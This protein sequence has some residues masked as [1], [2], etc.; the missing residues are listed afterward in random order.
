LKGGG[1]ASALQLKPVVTGSSG[2]F[3]FRNLPPGQYRV[4][5]D[6]SGYFH[7]SLEAGGSLGYDPRCTTC[8]R[9]PPE[10][11]VSRVYP[12][13][14]HRNERSVPI[15]L[16]ENQISAVTLPLLPGGV[17]TGRVHDERGRPLAGASIGAFRV[18]WYELGEPVLLRAVGVQATVD[19]R[20]EYRLFGLQPGKYYLRADNGPIV[21]SDLRKFS[22]YPG[23]A[24]GSAQAV[25]VSPGS[26][27]RNVNFGLQEEQAAIVSGS[28]TIAP[29]NSNVR[30]TPAPHR[31]H[32]L[33]IPAGRG[34]LDPDRVW[35]N[36]AVSAGVDPFAGK[37]E[38][39]G[40]RPGD[41]ELYVL[42][43]NDDDA[44]PD[45]DYFPAH[46]RITVGSTG[47][48]NVSVAIGAGS[49]IT[50]RIV[51]AEGAKLEPDL[52][53][54]VYLRPMAPVYPDINALT[55]WGD[56]WADVKP[57]GTFEISGLLD[58][59]Y[60]VTLDGLPSG[61]AVA[62]IR[63]GGRS[64]LEDGIVVESASVSM[65]I[66]VSGNAGTVR[67][68]VRDA[69]G[70]PVKDATVTLV[71]A[72]ESRRKFAVRTSFQAT[73]SRYAPFEGVPPGEYMLFAWDEIADGAEMNADLLHAYEDHGVRISVKPGQ[74]ITVD[75]PLISTEAVP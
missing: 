10:L 61:S 39:R 18:A 49:S 27:L 36:N 45:L 13:S 30:E 14:A 20:G 55:R 52:K 12:N 63:Q 35:F 66:V 24:E 51:M 70:Q 56:R 69:K 67:V 25:T 28:F 16:A 48:Q 64:V 46:Q 50:G 75:A 59:R 62:D 15:N 44:L 41:Y 43:R 31:L 7:P 26:E 22:Y 54:G 47:I 5:W 2:R 29:P 1:A 19:D 58:H 42:L 57:D 33:L 40:V 65:E 68:N 11:N 17:I 4:H 8:S 34:P 73:E 71:P 53:L 23:G 9:Y 38:L 3:E 6:R 74:A 72:A 32:F 21:R 37:F 60:L